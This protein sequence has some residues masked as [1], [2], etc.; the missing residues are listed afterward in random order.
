[1]GPRSTLLRE[2]WGSVL[3]QQLGRDFAQI[4]RSEDSIDAVRPSNVFLKK[5]LKL[6]F[7]RKKNSKNLKIN[8]DVY[9]ESVQDFFRT[10]SDFFGFCNSTFQRSP[11]AVF[12]LMQ[13]KFFR[14]GR[15]CRT[16]GALDPSDSKQGERTT[17]PPV[18]SNQRR[19]VPVNCHTKRRWRKKILHEP[20]EQQA[21]RKDTCF[22]NAP[23]L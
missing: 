17:P 11:R 12:E 10:F 20:S 21:S 18:A 9:L 4:F 3:L 6:R 1:M 5:V 23:T 2:S 19:T 7:H 14:R 16:K 8:H 15:R 13:S 22:R